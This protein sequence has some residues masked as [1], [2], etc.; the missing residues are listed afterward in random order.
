MRLVF[1]GA[2][3]AEELIVFFTGW[4]MD[5]GPFKPLAPSKQALALLF[6]YRDLNLPPLP[7]FPRTRIMA[8]SLGVYAALYHQE[9]LNGPLYLIAGT[10]AFTH[11][12]WGIPP[13]KV[14]LTLKALKE[15]GAKVLEEFYRRLFRKEKEVRMF[16]KNRPQ[17]PLEEVIEELETALTRKP[18]WPQEFHRCQA[19]IPQKDLI[20]PPKAQKTYWE[21]TRVSVKFISAPHFPFYSFPELLTGWK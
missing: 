6:D 17:R 9:R 3:E 15:R 20:F 12:E 1:W 16:F 14:K 11:R 4:A 5:E 2:P 8:W 21:K 7:S 10:G 19:L 18:I 13:Q